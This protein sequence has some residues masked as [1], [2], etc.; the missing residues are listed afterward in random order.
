[1]APVSPPDGGYGRRVPRRGQPIVK[2]GADPAAFDRRFAR[3]SMAGD[4]QY[5]PVAAP[6]RLL[7]SPIDRRPG[8]IEVVAVEIDDPIGFDCPSLEPPI[9]AS[10]ERRARPGL[11]GHNGFRPI[12]RWLSQGTRLRRGHFRLFGN[13]LLY[14]VSR[15]GPDRRRDPCPQRLLVRAERA[16]GRPRPWEAAPA[17]YRLRPCRRRSASPGRRHPRR[18]RSD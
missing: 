17:R 2:G 15:K 11:G 5:Y 16:H 9:P 1:M 12:G 14:D 13:R 6:N 10:V 4:Q 3:P 18:C 8:A 7:N